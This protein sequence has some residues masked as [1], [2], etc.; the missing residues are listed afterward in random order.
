LK[1]A[2]ERIEHLHKLLHGDWVDKAST[3]WLNVRPLQ[4]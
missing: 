3:T 4:R 1:F 2:A